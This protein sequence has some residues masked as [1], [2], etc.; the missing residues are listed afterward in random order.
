MRLAKRPDLD[1][2]HAQFEAWRA[3]GHGRRAFPDR[4]LRAAVDLLD[5]YPPS[6]VCRR[7]HLNATRFRRAREAFG[8]AGVKAIGAAS[9]FVELPVL[10][11]AVATERGPFAHINARGHTAECRVV[12]ETATGGRLSVEFARVDPVWLAAVCRLL[13]GD[14]DE[15]RASAHTTPRWARSAA[16]RP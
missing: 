12:L 11:M 4:L 7:L 5:R 16:T 9:A 14:N 1:D 6:T 3:S 15:T 10:G 2:V 8:V 13:V